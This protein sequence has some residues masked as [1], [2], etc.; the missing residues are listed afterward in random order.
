M[1][2]DETPPILGGIGW[3]DLTVPD[4]ETVRDFYKEVTGWNATDVSMGDYNDYCMHSPEDGTVVAGVCHA[5]G[6][7]E[8]LPAQWL[9]YIDVADLKQSI[10]RCIELGGKVLAEPRSSGPHGA[11][12]VI[13]DPAG[14]VVALFQRGAS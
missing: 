13:Q 10:Q 3:V 8:S 11:F 9:I 4:A 12:C 14:A 7:N 6:V 1:M 2:S 5:R